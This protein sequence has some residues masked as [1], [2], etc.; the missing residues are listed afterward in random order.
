MRNFSF[1][2]FVTLNVKDDVKIYLMKTNLQNQE[3]QVPFGTSIHALPPD[4]L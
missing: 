1:R 4:L 3:C 2:F